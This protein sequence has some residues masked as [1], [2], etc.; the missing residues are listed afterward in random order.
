MVETTVSSTAFVWEIVS[1]LTSGL[2]TSLT[3]VLFV[4]GFFGFLISV[5][6]KEFMKLIKS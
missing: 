6:K 3:T 2:T 1:F 5:L 4:A